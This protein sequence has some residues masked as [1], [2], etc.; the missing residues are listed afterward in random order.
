MNIF[1]LSK[2]PIISFCLAIVA[3]LFHQN[4]SAQFSGNKELSSIQITNQKDTVQSKR[5]ATSFSHY[6]SLE[7]RPAWVIPSRIYKTDLFTNPFDEFEQ[8][9]HFKYAFSL[10][11]DSL[12]NQVFPN[13][14]QGIG[15]AVYG[16]GNLKE[17]GRPIVAYFF[18][19][20]EITK[21][22]PHFSLNYEWNFGISTGWK[23][24]DP[25]NNPNNIIVG[26]KVNAFISLGTSISWKLAN[27]IL[28]FGGVDF[29]HFSNGNTKYP[30]AGVNLLGSKI[31]VVYDVSKTEIV[32]QEKDVRQSPK[33]TRH[34]SYDWVIFGSWR[35]KGVD[36]F[37]KQVASP[38]EYPVA[39]TYFAPM[40]NWGHRLRTGFSVDAI[41]DGSA[42]IYTED[43]IV[44]TEQQFFKPELNQ[45]IALGISVR[46]DYV[47]PLFTI[48]LGIGTHVLHKGEDFKGTYQALGLK[49]RATKNSFFNIGYNVKNFHNPNYLMFGIGYRFNNKTPLL[50]S[51]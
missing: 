46:V 51:K 23:P 27:N 45:Q 35:R 17:I 48:N 37:G 4:A 15:L 49:I 43:Y 6:L 22:S 42:N 8:S 24:Y 2:N 40:L 19:R 39:G 21:I 41:Y 7:Y 13:T 16:F 5:E 18:Q 47:M 28:L 36:F 38:H 1:K 26:S 3:V 11:E 20:S 31:G 30:N 29:T 12:G 10:P 9:G 50:M 32:P 44:G 14:Q 33:F 25:N 34:I